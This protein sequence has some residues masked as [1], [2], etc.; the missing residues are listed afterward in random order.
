MSL[1]DIALHLAATSRAIDE[2][3]PTAIGRCFAPDARLIV[4]DMEGLEEVTAGSAIGPGV[5]A[6]SAALGG[7]L[8]HVP[9][10]VTAS[11]INDHEAS[12]TSYTLYVSVGEA[13]LLGISESRDKLVLDDGRWLLTERRVVML[14]TLR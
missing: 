3:D 12:A 1:Q 14:S 5:S 2:C 4:Q 7:R 13:E 8:R 9:M 10:S 11:W 6:A